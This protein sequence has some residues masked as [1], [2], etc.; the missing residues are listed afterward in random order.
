M[1]SFIPSTSSGF[2][3]NLVYHTR[4]LLQYNYTIGSPP[5][6]TRRSGFSIHQKLAKSLEHIT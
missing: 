1:N 4:N 3:I 6:N 2:S 5:T